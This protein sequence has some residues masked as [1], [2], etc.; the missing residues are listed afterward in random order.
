MN[1]THNDFEASLETM[2]DGMNAV[3]K[4]GCED[5]KAR[6]LVLGS[7]SAVCM[8]VAI[9]FGYSRWSA[10]EDTFTDPEMAYAQVEQSLEEIFGRMSKS[11]ELV[12]E[13]GDKLDKPKEMI[14]KM[15]R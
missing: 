9:G 2:L 4:M 15:I 6:A 10:P 13:A 11:N 8:F 5:R 1:K 3:E 14:E 12:R 7:L